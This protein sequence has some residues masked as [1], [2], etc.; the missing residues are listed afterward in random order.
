MIRTKSIFLVCAAVMCG[1]ASVPP[2]PHPV[3]TSSA[4]E[5]KLEER[6]NAVS[7]LYDLFQDEKNVNKVLIIKRNTKELGEV[8]DAVAHTS[9]DAAK[10]ME[11]MAKADPMINLHALELPA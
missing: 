4:D 7:L 3:A 6:N 10:R 2:A 11:A 5:R 8:I 9:G 1:C